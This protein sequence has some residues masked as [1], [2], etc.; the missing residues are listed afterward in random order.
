MWSERS[1]NFILAVYGNESRDEELSLHE[2][3][4]EAGEYRAFGKE[5]RDAIKAVNALQ[6]A[7]TATTVRVRN[8]QLLTAEGPFAD[9]NEELESFYVIDA[10]HLDDAVAIAAKIPAARYGSIEVRP[11][12]SNVRRGRAPRDLRTLSTLSR[13]I[14]GLCSLVL[15]LGAFAHAKAFPRMSVALAK[16]SLPAIYANDFRT[17]WLADSTTL[18]TVALLFAWIAF[19]PTTPLKSALIMIAL[20]PASTALLLYRFVGSFYA[21]HLLLGTAAAAVCVFLF[22][23]R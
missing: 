6:P 1:M 14:L 4:T 8:G 18:L 20:I 22:R 2:L 16:V 9:R 13:S 15:T 17:L 5:F 19:R 11:A 23:S 12:G 7:S 21:A 3:R 10:D